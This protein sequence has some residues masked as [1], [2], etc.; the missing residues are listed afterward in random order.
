M[1][2]FTS[3]TQDWATSPMGNKARWTES[4]TGKEK[5]RHRFFLQSYNLLGSLMRPGWDHCRRNALL[6]SAGP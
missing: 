4:R 6:R 1:T 3:S 5:P 2:E